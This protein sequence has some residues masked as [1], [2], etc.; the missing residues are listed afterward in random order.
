VSITTL[1][2]NTAASLEGGEIPRTPRVQFTFEPSYRF[3]VAG[4]STRVYASIYTVDRRFQDFS[5]LS[6]LSAYTTLDVGA[7]VTMNGFEVRG[8]VSNVTNTVGLTEGNARAS[9]IGSGA[10][11]DATVGR[12]IF[13]RNF[14]LS[15]TKRW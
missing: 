11:G 10:V 12:S 6:R 8:V 13:G 1:T 4:A 7:S 9:V 2:G 5:N 15:L 14:T 3:N